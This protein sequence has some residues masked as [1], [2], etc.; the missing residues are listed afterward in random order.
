LSVFSK[1]NIE[2]RKKLLKYG[3]KMGPHYRRWVKLLNEGKL[4]EEFYNNLIFKSENLKTLQKY[5]IILKD[6]RMKNCLSFEKNIYHII[7]HTK[8]NFS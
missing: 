2:N 8:K 3:A 5:G 4:E 6:K 1:K 7:S